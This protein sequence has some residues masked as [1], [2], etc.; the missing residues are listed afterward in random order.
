V[1]ETVVERYQETADL[2]PLERRSLPLIVALDL[3]RETARLLD[4]YMRR[5]EAVLKPSEY[6]LAF[7]AL[8][9]NLDALRGILP[10]LSGFDE[11]APKRGRKWVHRPKRDA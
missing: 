2:A 4:I 8:E 10:A 11:P 5:D 9:R 6:R 7:N 3:L 1:I